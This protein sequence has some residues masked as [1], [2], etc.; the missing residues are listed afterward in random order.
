MITV[1]DM[2]TSY[3][4]VVYSN[5]VSFTTSAHAAIS[6]PT[7]PPSSVTEDRRRNRREDGGD[8]DDDTSPDVT[9]ERR[10]H[11]TDG[12]IKLTWRQPNRGNI[13]RSVFNM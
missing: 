10:D 11:K 12:R 8:G 9:L 4:I 3:V 1:M 2:E 7:F 13:G 5:D 6:H